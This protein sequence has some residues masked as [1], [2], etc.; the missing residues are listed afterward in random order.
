MTLAV[1]D[2][3]AMAAPMLGML[4]TPSAVTCAEEADPAEVPA[5]FVAVALNVY[6]VP[7]VN[8]VTSQD[9]DAPVTVHDPAAAEAAV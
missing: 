7:P 1:V 8:P 3:V 9:P 4:G 5:E 6:G 2:P